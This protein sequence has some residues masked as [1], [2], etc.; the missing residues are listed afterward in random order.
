M[1]VTTGAS[2]GSA[3]C[4]SECGKVLREKELKAPDYQVRMRGVGRGG[5]TGG[6]MNV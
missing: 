3:R 1:H 2:D 5:K 4:G 6:E